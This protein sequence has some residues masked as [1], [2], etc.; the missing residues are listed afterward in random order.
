MFEWFHTQKNDNDNKYEIFTIISAV[1]FFK[2]KESYAVT[3]IFC[4]LLTFT[5][6]LFGAW[7]I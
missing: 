5:H 6:F 7:G 4:A 1:D 2:K 3:I